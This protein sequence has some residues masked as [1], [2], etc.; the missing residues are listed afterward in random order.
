MK[1][2]TLFPPLV[3]VIL[4]IVSSSGD[5]KGQASGLWSGTISEQSYV[6]GQ[7]G[8]QSESMVS[9]RFNNNEGTG[10]YTSTGIL[11]V[12][13]KVLSR[14][15]CSGTYIVGFGE[16]S[17][18][19]VNKT[20]TIQTS[21][22]I[23]TCTHLNASSDSGEAYITVAYEPWDE[24]PKLL[25]G[26]KMIVTDIPG[27]GKLTTTTT[28]NLFKGSEVELIVTPTDYDRWLPIPG[29]DEQSPGPKMMNVTL[30]LKDR[31]GRSASEKAKS[32]KLRL[33]NTS[34]E[35]GI[36]INMP[37]APA[38]Q[39]MPDL[40]FHPQQNAIITEE[41]QSMIISC[42]AGCL[43]ANFKIACYDGGAWTTLTAVALLETDS[44]KGS[45]LEPGGE[46][47]ILIPKREPDSRIGTAWLTENE[48]P[49]DYFDEESSPG[50]L[51]KGDGL[52]AYEEYRG[53]MRLRVYK[54]LSA[55]KKELGILTKESEIGIFSLGFS[56]FQDQTGILVILFDKSEIQ[57][58]RRLNK[59]TSYGHVFDQYVLRVNKGNTGQADIY[60][61]AMDAWGVA[62][63]APD[64]PARITHIVI[65]VNAINTYYQ[66]YSRARPNLPYTSGD[67]VA[68][69]TAHEIGHG[70]GLP[71]HGIDLPRLPGFTVPRDTIPLIRIFLERGS[72]EITSRPYTITGLIG[73]P[74]NHE[75]GNVSCFICYRNKTNWVREIVNNNEQHFYKVPDL[76][77]GSL[78]CFDQQ[79]TDINANNR[80]YRNAINGSCLRNIKLRD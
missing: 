7:P 38:A 67:L 49:T 30:E 75:S 27:G 19:N 36:T 53:V 71:H 77:A 4:I 21:A 28:W 23:Y 26:S 42:P 80:Y 46:K 63:G 69:T 79:G 61:Q 74:N 76:P 13:G 18:D 62:Y 78:F 39:Q 40:R 73:S 1:K 52:S 66:L 57:E 44:I 25:K 8:V 20:Y 60:G 17:I 56:R 5:A 3:L 33:S 55:K 34:K 54:R 15:N 2:N 12:D 68:S 29:T 43:T 37:L 72:P 22:L 16:L 64:I 51:N 31:N 10:T 45:L 24:N 6:T 14:D 65:D 32:F 9:I 58:N 70:V 50:N 41:G 59:N 47:N 35:R 48:N 11:T